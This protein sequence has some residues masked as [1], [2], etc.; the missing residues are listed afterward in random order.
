MQI[1]IELPNDFVTFQSQGQIQRDISL[2][3][4]PW[5]FKNERVTI[6][7]AAELA[8]LDIYDFI[9]ACKANW[10]SVIDISREQLLEGG[11]KKICVNCFN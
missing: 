4:A 1:A 6:A 9:A 10:V 2:S 11:C 3:Y 8:S 7:K 5:L